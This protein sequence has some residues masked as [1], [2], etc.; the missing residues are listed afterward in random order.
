MA[1]KKC[2]RFLTLV[3]LK[4]VG[5]GMDT[6]VNKSFNDT[7]AWLAPK[8]KVYLRSVSLT[9]QVNIAIATATLGLKVFYKGILHGFH[10]ITEGIKH[11]LSIIKNKCI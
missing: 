10:S 8:S 3:A 1:T 4:E 2:V 7:A 9:N 11:F 6:L 5:H